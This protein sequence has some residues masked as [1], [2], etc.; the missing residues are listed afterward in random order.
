MQRLPQAGLSC[1]QCRQKKSDLPVE[2]S[3]CLWAFDAKL[4]QGCSYWLAVFV[5][6]EPKWV[7]GVA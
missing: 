1:A 4:S 5:R 2:T 7:G 6:L 3:Y